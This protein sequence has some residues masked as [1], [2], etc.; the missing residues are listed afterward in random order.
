MLQP[1]FLDGISFDLV[2]L[3]HRFICHT[4]SPG[5]VFQCHKLL[6]QPRI[7]ITE[8]CQTDSAQQRQHQQNRGKTKTDRAEDD[9]R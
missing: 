1:Q 3:K 7:L 4:Q 9:L 5:F 2:Q 6:L 8:C